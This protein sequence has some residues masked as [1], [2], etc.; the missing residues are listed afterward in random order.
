MKNDLKKNKAISNLLKAIFYE[1]YK[2]WT[3]LQLTFDF[4]ASCFSSFQLLLEMVGCDEQEL[5][6]AA[7]GCLSNIRKVA[8]AASQK[9]PKKSQTKTTQSLKK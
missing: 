5:Q 7:A 3:R 1:H 4:M 6:E 8:T 9:Q 2:M